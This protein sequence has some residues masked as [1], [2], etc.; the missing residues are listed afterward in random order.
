MLDAVPGEITYM[1]GNGDTIHSDLGFAS[2]ADR[3]FL[4]K[5]LD[6]FLDNVT[7]SPSQSLFYLGNPS[8]MEE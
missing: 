5:V 7:T 3:E 8:L 1:R 6:E 4:H 2:E